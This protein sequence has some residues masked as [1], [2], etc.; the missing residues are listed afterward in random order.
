MKIDISD[1]LK[2]DGASLDV[3]FEGSQ[4]DFDI[5]SIDDDLIFADPI[6]F[7]GKLVNVSGVIKLDGSLEADYTAVCYRC[8]KK[9][10][11]RMKLDIKEEFV[12]AS[13]DTDGEMY[14]YE[15]KYI[16]LGK[17]LKDNIVLNL[18][19]KQVCTSDCKGLC[20]KC[21][22]NLNE[23]ECSCKEEYINPQMEVLKNFFNN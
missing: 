9:I 4:E 21:G 2:F 1:I 19:M 14:T 13:K 15:G 11:R 20:P 22:E 18:P 12:D 7:D 6:R 17:A 3:K 8:L 16:D 10:D 23:K 5:K